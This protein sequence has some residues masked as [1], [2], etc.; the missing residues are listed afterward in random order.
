MGFGFLFLVFF[1]PA[2]SRSTVGLQPRNLEVIFLS[3]SRSVSCVFVRLSPSRR[4]CTHAALPPHRKHRLSYPLFSAPPY[5]SFRLTL[6]FSPHASSLTL[7]VLVHIPMATTWW[8]LAAVRL[9][10][11]TNATSFQPQ[12]RKSTAGTC[13]LRGS[14][15]RRRA[16]GP[17]VGRVQ[18]A[19]AHRP[20]PHPR[21]LQG[22][23]GEAQG[24]QHAPHPAARLVSSLLS[25]PPFSFSLSL[26]VCLSLAVE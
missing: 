3:T 19:D 16:R 15:N 21:P 14:G 17:P 8:L 12:R 24:L 9:P 20:V 23:R 6:L 22:R 1:S 11:C 13:R 26:C 10:L 18:R 2:V 25:P 5:L 4:A 7:L